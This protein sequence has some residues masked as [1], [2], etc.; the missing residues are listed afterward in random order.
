MV[1]KNNID[2][3]NR[4]A[5]NKVNRYGIRRLSV[6][7]ASVAVAGLLFMADATLVQAAEAT[8]GEV[9]TATVD[10]EEAPV[11]E[12]APAEEVSVNDKEV[13][14]SNTAEEQPNEDVVAD[15]EAAP[16][17][18]LSDE[19]VPATQGEGQEDAPAQPAIATRDAAAP[20]ESD[21]ANDARNAVHAF[22]GV[23]TGGDLNLK[24]EGATGQQFKPIEGVRA[25][26]QWFEDGGHVSPVYTAVSDANGRL[27]I[28]AKPY[29][30]G[31]GKLI[32]FD[33]DPTVSGG[34][35]KYRFWVDEA[36]IPEGYQ[37]QYITG[38]QVV[39]PDSALPITQGGSGS[40]TPRNTHENWKILLMQKPKAEMHREDAK[41]TPVQSKTGGYMTGTVSWDYSSGIGGIQWNQVADHTTPAPGVTVRASYLSDY[42]MKQIF[43]AETARLMGVSDASKIRGTGWTSA[44]EAE[45][46]K[47]VKEQV[48]K[49][50]TKWIAETVTAKTN[51]EGKY[52]LQ[53]NG[54]WGANRNADAAGEYTY[55]VGDNS[56]GQVWNKWTQEQIDRLGKVAESAN[57]GSFDRTTTTNNVKHINYD[58]LFV[59]TDETD[60]LR[61]MTPYNNNYYT[62]MN[63]NWGIHSG[64]SGTGFGVG[65]TN[66]VPSILR[67]DFVLGINNVEFGITNY[68]SGANT[69]LPGDVA[70]TKTTGLP[71]SKTSE[72]FRI[73]WYD[74]DGKVVKEGKAVQPDGTGQIPSEPFDTTGVTKTTEFTAKLYRVDKNGKDAELIAVDSF[75]VQISNLVASRYDEY[76]IKNPNPQKN[77]VYEAEGLPDGLT[78]D[79][80]NGTISGKPTKAGEYSVKVS[81]TIQDESGDIKGS[82]NYTALITDSPLENGEVG[83]AYNQE[84][85]PQEIEGY[86]FKNV[87]SK[88]IDGKAIEGLTIENNQITGT[89]T[90][91]VL[92]T[93]TTDDGAMGPNVEVTYDIYKLNSK[94]EEILVKKGHVD[95]VP[96]SIKD[97]EAAK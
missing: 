53:F 34:H 81:T 61:V 91:Q 52:I 48:A 82:R 41:E 15:S 57:D 89:P 64:W 8:E 58:W 65:V 27:N 54:I 63:S 9:S 68:D 74:Q 13:E 87:T 72:R 24:L 47:W 75:T 42:A 49:D 22:V 7:V 60:G 51:A 10:E 43:S 30:A 1:G 55:K 40:D 32:K 66:A 14:P 16:S 4:K 5:A 96:L 23:Q 79:P 70:E 80:A 19:V 84:V 26:F 73:V 95:N 39:F 67:S 44:Q 86:V 97:G 50:P 18:E 28:G 31:D 88:F 36:T 45:L 35:E 71:Y 11:A 17:L 83:V 2:A 93:Q 69:A 38:E 62:S 76:E 92:A 37:L 78:I 77:G 6:G 12:E 25:Y 33:A 20:E 90:K 85:K 56:S 3:L 46:Q 59:S 94:G 21:V 29:I